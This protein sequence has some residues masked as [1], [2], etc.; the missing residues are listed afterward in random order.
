MQLI[1][2]VFKAGVVGAGGAGF[3]THV[4]LQAKVDVIVANGAECEPL[5]ATDRRVM[6]QYAQEIVDGMRLVMETTG[7]K[8]GIIGVKEKYED[9]LH[10]FGTALSGVN[11]IKIHLLGNF[12]PAGDEFVLVQ[13]TTGRII[14]EGG[15]PLNVGVVVNNVNTLRNIY[16]AYNDI[17]VTHQVVTVNGE[18]KIPM[19]LDVPIGMA[20]G[21][22]I[23]ICEGTTVDDYIVIVG[24]PMMGRLTKNLNEPITKTTTGIIVLPSDHSYVMRKSR[25]VE[26]EIRWSQSQCDQC[27]DCTEFCPRWLQGHALEP[28]KVM[29][30]MDYNLDTSPHAKTI[31]SS[32]L[33]SE[34][35]VC[36]IFSCP[37]NLSPRV[38]FKELKQRLMQ[39]GLKNPHSNAPK[40]GRSLAEYRKVPKDRLIQRLD[41]AK[42][43]CYPELAKEEL[44]ASQVRIPLRQHIG[45]PARP[46][47]HFGDMVHKG[48]LIGAV[49]QNQ[50]GAN[51]HASITGKVVDVAND[52]I[53][54]K[55]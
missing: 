46:L 10:A 55:A 53:T 45:V 8:E 24:G 29:R 27:R 4:K 6:A 50:L 54:I 2:K 26:E 15:L 34:C 35:G 21:D 47:V 1:E 3:P 38:M 42:Y 52:H 23:D 33:C 5:L 32:F 37:M 18:V 51:I 16:R 14:P 36:D 39:E 25:T 22:L 13:E 7:A 31:T 43:D 20:I 12:Y 41:M 30:V 40:E 28:H 11:N 9:A 19:V 48:D 17:P 44:V 49:E